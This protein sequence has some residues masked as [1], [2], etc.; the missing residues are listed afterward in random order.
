LLHPLR[1]NG[2]DLRDLTGYQFKCANALCREASVF[3]ELTPDEQNFWLIIADAKKNQQ[4]FPAAYEF[5]WQNLDFRLDGYL[6]FATARRKDINFLR[7]NLENYI[8]QRDALLD[9][10][11]ELAADPAFLVLTN[12][13][14]IPTHQLEI[15]LALSR[16]LKF[17]A[18]L[19]ELPAPA[20]DLILNKTERTLEKILL[21]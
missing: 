15:P 12:Q 16:L 11:K 13:D 3:A 7:R 19:W 1:H 9:E 2:K 4:P 18:E 17:G 10:L 20:A 5:L 8:S 21:S 14:L 6:A